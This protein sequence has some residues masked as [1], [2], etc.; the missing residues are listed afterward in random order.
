MT[1]DVFKLTRR[2]GPIL[3]AMP[4]VGTELPASIADR[5]G[6]VG[7]SVID[8]DWHVDLLYQDMAERL[9][10]STLRPR[11]SR[12]VID[13]NRG[14]D[15]APLYPGQVSTGLLPHKTFDGEPLYHAGKEPGPDET[16]VRVRAYWAPY[17]NALKE[18]LARLRAKW[19]YAI[20]WDAHSIRSH[21]PRLFEG[22]LPDLNLGTNDG[23]AC[24]PVLAK[25]LLAEAAKSTAYTSVLDGRFKGGF[26]TRN[27]GKPADKVH[28]VQLELC[29]SC[30]LQSEEAPFDYD[31]KKGAELGACIES[32][33]TVAKNWRF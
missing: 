31:K 18:E 25:A 33:L 23:K 20:L 16:P 7:K 12:Y 2:D 14:S 10:C 29:Q 21:V 17:H 5:Y 26:T 32:L 24:D 30:Y 22:K 4:H 9:G 1:E 13:L 6:P 8:T 11:Y 15:D 3:I 19:G 28:A 27:Y